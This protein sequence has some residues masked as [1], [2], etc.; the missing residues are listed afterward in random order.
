MAASDSILVRPHTSLELPLKPPVYDSNWSTAQKALYGHDLQEMWDRSIAPHIW[1]QYHNQLGLYQ[2]L[3]ESHPGSLPKRILDVGCAQATLAILL[4]ERGHLVTAVD[5]RSEFIDYAKS[6]YTHGQIEFLSG[7][8]LRLELPHRYDVVFA[9]QIIEHLVY[10][11]ILVRGLANLLGPGGLLVVTTP[12]WHYFKNQ[13]PKFSDIGDRKAHEHRQFTSDADGHFFAYTADELAK[14]FRDAQL[15]NLKVVPFETPL[16][17]GH[18]RVRHLHGIVPAPS[19]KRIDSL[20]LRVP[21]IRYLLG[22]QLMVVGYK[23]N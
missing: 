13:L 7:N 20:L 14:V 15:E 19:L 21:G 4:A 3:V 18:F 16:I 11:E 23:G 22:H 6:R 9:N 10:P 2:E 17:S 12:S 8:A 1:N 5:L